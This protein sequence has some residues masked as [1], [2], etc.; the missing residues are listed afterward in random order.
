MVPAPERKTPRP[1]A[2]S[3]R[4]GFSDSGTSSTSHTF[5]PPVG[6]DSSSY[7]SHQRSESNYRS[8]LTQHPMATQTGTSPYSSL[9]GLLNATCRLSGQLIWTKLKT[10]DNQR[11]FITETKTLHSNRVSTKTWEDKEATHTEH[12]SL[13]RRH[14][15][16][17]RCIKL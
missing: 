14:Q 3:S 10:H 9:I 4:S 15:Q 13:T 2:R 11:A 6:T 8:V 5:I 16:V 17:R 1:L 12:P 7:R